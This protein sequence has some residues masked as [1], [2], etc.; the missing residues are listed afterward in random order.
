VRALRGRVG[1]CY[2]LVLRRIDDAAR[3]AKESAMATGSD[4]VLAIAYVA[5]IVGV[6]YFLWYRPQQVQRKKMRE[7]MASLAPG[8]EVMTAGGLIGTVRSMDVDLVTVEIAA[9]V[10]VRFTRRAI[11]DRINPVVGPG[12]E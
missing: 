2:H 3:T 12:D 9:G 5:A 10:L 11:I 8:D 7:L 4:P 6:F 1:R